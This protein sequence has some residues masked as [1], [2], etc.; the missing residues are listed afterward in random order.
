M[1]SVLAIII[2]LLVGSASV[3]VAAEPA[4][5]LINSFEVPT[6][7]TEETIKMWEKARDFLKAEPG[8]ISTELHQATTPGA[9]FRLVNVAKWES[10]EAY[11]AASKKMKT[12]AGLPRIEGLSINPALYTVIR[13]N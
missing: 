10:V 3:S 6:G 11:A 1:K 12:Q 2:A 5:V 4:Y 7:K 9:R 13:G 8:Y